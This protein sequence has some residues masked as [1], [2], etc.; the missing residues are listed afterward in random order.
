[1][2]KLIK[3]TPQQRI[4][5]FLKAK[6]KWLQKTTFRK[7]KYINKKDIHDIHLWDT[8]KSFK[9]ISAMLHKSKAFNADTCPFCFYHIVVCETCTYGK[10]H[11]TCSSNVKNPWKKYKDLLP[12][13]SATTVP[14]EVMNVLKVE[15]ENVAY[16]KKS[17]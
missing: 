13:A 2:K 7:I 8:D 15:E 10:H 17:L 4:I 1:M 14:P 9:I 3:Y 12:H 6:Q 11:G 16:V 5:N